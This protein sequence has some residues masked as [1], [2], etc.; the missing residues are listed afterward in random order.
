MKVKLGEERK[1]KCC[2]DVT[3]Q[4]CGQS[5]MGFVPCKVIEEK[6]VPCEE[7]EQYHADGWR[8]RDETPCDG[9]VVMTKF[10]PGGKCGRIYGGK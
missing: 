3:R 2:V 5:C 6:A 10:F 7:V 8:D 4:C 1:M 9:K